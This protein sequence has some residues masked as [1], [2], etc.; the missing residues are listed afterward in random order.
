MAGAGTGLPLV[1]K[2]NAGLPVLVDGAA[3]YPETP[4]AVV[5]S[6]LR[7]RGLG[8]TV[9]G[10]CCGGTAEHVRAIAVAMGPR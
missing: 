10:I 3:V 6:A 2:P 1:F 8:A 4:A 7:A 9:L 5:A